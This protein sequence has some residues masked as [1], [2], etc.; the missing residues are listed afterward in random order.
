MHSSG[1]FLQF[2]V[3]MLL[4][5][6][7]LVSIPLALVCWRLCVTRIQQH[8]IELARIKIAKLDGAF[9]KGLVDGDFYVA[10]QNRKITDK[11]LI[12]ISQDFQRFPGPWLDQ[13]HTIVLDVSG[14]PITD[15]AVPHLVG[16]NFLSV[17]LANT[18]ITDRSIPY[19]ERLTLMNRL[20]ISDTQISEAGVQRLRRT[21][22]GR[23][24]V[25]EDR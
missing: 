2:R 13:R 9:D 3:R 20:D 18:R 5:G 22:P 15:D 10:L 25:C 11:Q 4:L 21:F 8:A 12:D 24:L 16:V 6:V 23:R 14:N 1:G 19:L 7:L 17:N